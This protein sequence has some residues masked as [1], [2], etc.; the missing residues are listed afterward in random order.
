MPIV[1]DLRYALRLMR[2]SP[3]FTAVA[4]AALALGTGANSAMFSVVNAILIRPLPYS[5]A[6]RV[7]IIWEKSTGQGWNRIN[8]SGPDILDFREQSTTLEQVAALETGTGTINGMGEPQ[9]VPGLRVSTNF[10]PLLG[11]R[12]LFGRDFKPSEGW[13]DRV[14]ILSHAAWQRWFAG[15]PNAVGKGLRLDGLSYTIIGVLPSGAWLPLPCDAFV[16]WADSDLRAKNRM[17]KNLAALV[18]LKPGVTWKQAS[19]ELDTIEHRIAEKTPRMQNWSAYVLSFQD[20]ISQRARPAL[21]LMLAAVGLVLLIACTNLANLMLAR[22]AGRERDMAVRLALGAG[23]ATLVRQF[24]TE[25]I[26]LGLLGGVAGLLIAAWGV[27]ILNRVVPVNL[28]MPDS[29]ADFVRPRIA[30]DGGVLAFTAAV[31]L[32]SGVLFGLAPAL[33]ASRASIGGLLRGSRGSAS[34]R[35]RSVRNALVVAEIALAVVLLTAATLTIQSFWNMRQVQPGF[36]SDHLLV[37]E[38]ELPTDSRYRTDAE[39]ARFHKSVLEKIAEI[40]GVSAVG[41]SCSLPMDTEDHKEDFRIFGK[42]LPPSGQMFSA[43]YRSVSAGYFA[44]MRIPLK[45]GRMLDGRDDAG[46]PWVALIDE[47]AVQRYFTDGTNPIGQKIGRTLVGLE[48]VGIVGNVLNDG[49]DKQAEPT[50]YASYLQ[51]PE[52]QVRYVVRHPSPLAAINTIKSAFY[53]VDKD[54]P[55]Y[56]IRT[57]DD[58][59]SGSQSGSKLALTLVAAFALVALVLAS[60]GI[61]GVVSF[62]VTQRTNE[63]GIRMALG[64]SVG[65]ILRLILGGGMKLAAIGVVLGIAAGLAV[66]QLLASLLF[67]VSSANPVVFGGTA[68]ILALV[69]LAATFLPA[70]RAAH[71]SPVTALRYE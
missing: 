2:R 29:N 66:S 33:A 16:P 55:V 44:A 43:H 64:A 20:W 7:G 6:D 67:G 50:I 36:A 51:A 49:L 1:D 13:N 59:V 70:L 65:D 41:L 23:R 68:L 71:T 38:T 60:L 40:P 25:T 8:P 54:Q 46:R 61:Y 15:D 58:V 19:A 52:A 69:A 17:E 47:A 4:I 28:R 34:A 62:G 14:L 63:I 24:L 45:R 3:G 31:A 27:D 37:V 57:M 32:L 35:T 39:Q 12:P 42:P 11:I 26:V 56:N 30:I 48:I 18:K 10:F 21:L 22:A 5:A 9:Q 53:A